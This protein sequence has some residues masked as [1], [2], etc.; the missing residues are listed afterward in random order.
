VAAREGLVRFSSNWRTAVAE[1]KARLEND[2]ALVPAPVPAADAVARDQVAAGIQRAQAAL[3]AEPSPPRW[4]SG[5]LVEQAWGGLQ[6]AR[7]VLLLIQDEATLRAQ[8][9]YL[10]SLAP[11]PWDATYSKSIAAEIETALAGGDLPSRQMLAQIQRQHDVKTDIQHGAVR[12]IRNKVIGAAAL[13]AGVLIVATVVL[14]A[15]SSSTLL[16]VMLVGAIAGAGTTVFPLAKARSSGGPYGVSGAQAALK[17]PAGA[18]AALLGVLLLHAGV[19]G[20]KPAT[21]DV[22]W[23]YAVVFGLSQQ[24][25]THLVD[26]QAQAIS[27]SAT[28][29]PG[30]LRQVALHARVDR[31]LH[32]RPRGRRGLAFKMPRRRRTWSPADVVGR[33]GST[34]PSSNPT[35]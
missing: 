34:E 17:V 14:V 20:L 13:M 27:G 2:L 18:A 6:S 8:L 9:L 26:R 31:P 19:G 5:E 3:D 35:R 10:A 21:G 29:A 7:E 22:V 16:N 24:A 12:Q 28:P 33:D 23:F 11:K 4:W 1:Q 32:N 30:R 15:M 25:L